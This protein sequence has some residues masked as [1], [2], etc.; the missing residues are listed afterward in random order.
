MLCS[1]IYSENKF[2]NAIAF[3]MLT[4]QNI[5]SHVD[6]A[7]YSALD[8]AR[9]SKN[10]FYRNYCLIF[11]KLL[12]VSCTLC[13]KFDHQKIEVFLVPAAQTSNK[14]QCTLRE[15]ASETFL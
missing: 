14:N 3:H 10:E 12:R 8:I 2:T 13:I 11:A 4:W 5:E 6:L 15:N 1:T 9:A 7:E